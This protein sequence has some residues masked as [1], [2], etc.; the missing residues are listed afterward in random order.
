MLC[1]ISSGGRRQSPAGL[2]P[3]FREL[4]AEKTGS[5]WDKTYDIPDW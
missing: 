2:A 1:A 4:K 3:L 5:Q